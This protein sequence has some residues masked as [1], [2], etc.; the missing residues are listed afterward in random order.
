MK[1]AKKPIAMLLVLLLFLSLLPVGVFAAND[2]EPAE[3]EAVLEALTTEEPEIPEEEPE[4]PEVPEV[5]EEPET[6]EV[7]EVP[8]APEVPEEPETPE[9]PEAPDEPEAPIVPE[10][11]EEPEEPAD[12]FDTIEIM[13]EP[14]KA[15]KTSEGPE[16]N[17]YV[18]W[19]QTII[20]PETG[21][22]K[23]VVKADSD[24]YT[25]LIAES[26]TNRYY[27]ASATVSGNTTTY[28]A[29][30]VRLP[31]LVNIICADLSCF[32]K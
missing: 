4:E 10:V 31:V 30:D 24:F 7:P 29:N 15:R 8:E 25:Y 26:E 28:Y 11:P 22:C 3:E 9:V 12:D 19:E 16:V 14:I 2:A 17:A 23:L 13:S 5:P 21:N 18:D 1:R 32:N 20:D 27:L 6:P